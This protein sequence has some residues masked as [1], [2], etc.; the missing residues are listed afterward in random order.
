M[1][2]LTS[3]GDSIVDEAGAGWFSTSHTTAPPVAKY[4]YYC[5]Q[6]LN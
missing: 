1:M 2:S 5:E 4:I 6:F 3:V